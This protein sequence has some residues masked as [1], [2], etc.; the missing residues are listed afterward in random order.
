MERKGLSGSALKIIAIVT[1]LIDHIAATVI[2]RILKFGGYNDGLYQLYRVMRNIGRIAFPIFCFLLVEG[3]MHTRDREKYA[4][5]LGCFA[6]VSEIPFDLAFNGKVLEV[7]YQN[8][9][10]TLLLGLLTMMAYDA[11]MNQSRWSVWKRTALSTI[12]ILAGM[13]AAEFLSTDYGALGVLCIMVFYLFRRSRI[14]QVVFGC[15]AFVW[16]E[17]AAVFA[18]VPIFYYNGKRGFGMKYF[19]YAFYPVH[20]LILYLI[21]YKMGLCYWICAAVCGNGSTVSHR[22]VRNLP[23]VRTGMAAIECIGSISTAGS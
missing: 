1:M 3:F 21:V 8:V 22:S 14:Q 17:W 16:W 9:F 18:F 12:A 4:L 6:A 10:F 15:L 5:R 20:L 19:F 23:S 11:V 13:F 2:I 7:G